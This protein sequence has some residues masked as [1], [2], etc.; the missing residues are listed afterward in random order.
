M[1]I[2]GSGKIPRKKVKKTKGKN[3]ANSFRFKSLKKVIEVCFK[4]P[5]NIL[6]ESHKL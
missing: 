3:R 2:I 5:N 6:F 1:S 4:F